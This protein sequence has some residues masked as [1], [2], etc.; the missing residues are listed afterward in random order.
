VLEALSC[1]LPMVVSATPMYRRLAPPGAILAGGVDEWVAALRSLAGD[2]ALRARLG[3][4]GRAW[5]ERHHDSDEATRR[6]L[7]L[8]GLEDAVRPAR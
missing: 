5:I 2:R 6:L 1:G 7:A 3:K 8:L 4:A